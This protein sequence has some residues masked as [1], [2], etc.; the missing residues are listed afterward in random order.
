MKALYIAYYTALRNLRDHTNLTLM[1]LFPIVMIFILGSA[2]TGSFEIENM[3]PIEVILV[4]EDEGDL[5]R[6]FEG[7]LNSEEIQEMLDVEKADSFDD[8]M[9]RVKQGEASALIHLKKDFAGQINIYDSNSSVFGSSVLKNV[10]DVFIQSANT[11]YASSRLGSTAAYI[12][13]SDNI[14]EEAVNVDGKTPS[15]LDY[16]AISMLLMTMMYGTMYGCSAMSEERFLNTDIRL[17]SAPLK[18]YQIYIGKVTGTILTLMIDAVLIIL[19][20]KYV[21]KVNWGS[22]ILAIMFACLSLAVLAAGIGVTG[23]MLIGD[24]SK[25]QVILNVLVPLFT[26]L[27][28]GYIPSQ[29]LSPMMKRISVISPNHLARN[30]MS[31][32]IYEGSHTQTVSF[33]LILWAV[34]LALFSISAFGGR[35]AAA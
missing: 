12:H 21:Y 11:E 16:Y 28:G 13:F 1:L 30:I 18:T 9:R 34:S 32:I 2:L 33:L 35:R 17:K 6:S 14:I 22:N 19:F 27:G 3:E 31:N 8:S 10:I 23:F 25:T 24:E 15:S 20:T 26:F 29:Y 4:N 5:S 7:F